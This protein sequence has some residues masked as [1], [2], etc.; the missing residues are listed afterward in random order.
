MRARNVDYI[1]NCRKLIHSLPGGWD[2]IYKCLPDFDD[3]VKNMPQAVPDPKSKKGKT[4]FRFYGKDFIVQGGAYW[5]GVGA[6]PDGF[7][8]LQ[9]YF[10]YSSIID[11]IKWIENLVPQNSVAKVSEEERQRYIAERSAQHKNG[12]VLA[13]ADVEKRWVSL[14]KLY[15]KSQS[16]ASSP[17]VRE[18]LSSR[19]ITRLLGKMPAQLGY[20]STCYYRDTG[21]GM[22]S[23]HP[24]M[25]GI[26]SDAKG[27][28]LT[29]HRTYLDNSGTKAALSNPKKVMPPP[30]DMR[31]GAIQLYEPL[32]IEDQKAWFL[33][34][35]E[36]IETALSVT[37]S[38]NI[39]CWSLYSASLLEMMEL[40]D[41]L[42]PPGDVKELNLIIAIDK[43][44]PNPET[45]VRAGLVAG[46]R[47]KKRMLDKLTDL[48]PHA[49][50]NV[51][52]CE[53]SLDIPDGKKGVDWNDELISKGRECFP[54]TLSDQY[55]DMLK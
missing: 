21:T 11:V 51:M 3:A 10:G 6:L 48:Y 25:L 8:V 27:E 50:V 17:L 34:V 42:L 32:Y 15:R 40:P 43:D 20:I 19:G 31:G 22:A 47:L 24:A 38:S 29:I 18:Y 39:P 54:V 16:A 33:G 35:A 44:R 55:F 26:F 2:S 37:E 30:G 46:E 12:N 23:I 4:V 5:N 53:P 45:G 36:G 9:H 41:G 13:P 1:G 14:D 49:K 52:I 28:N 7:A